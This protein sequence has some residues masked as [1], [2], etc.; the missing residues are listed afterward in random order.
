M[1]ALL[2]ILQIIDK[3]IKNLVMVIIICLVAQRLK[4]SIQGR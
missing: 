1:N 4:V 2:L 3:P